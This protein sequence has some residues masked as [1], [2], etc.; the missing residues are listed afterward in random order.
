M[1]SEGHCVRVLEQMLVPPARLQDFAFTQIEITT[2]GSGPSVALLLS[3]VRK[4]QRTAEATEN[5]K[6][7]SYKAEKAKYSCCSKMST[8][9]MVLV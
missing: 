2:I 8:E 5:F 3:A 6:P 7:E 4:Y 1:S 9:Q